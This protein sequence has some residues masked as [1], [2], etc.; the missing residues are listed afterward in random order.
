[1][2]FLVPVAL[3]LVAPNSDAR[4]FLVVDLGA[5]RADAASTSA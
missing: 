1:M 5:R 2:N 4:K 3:E